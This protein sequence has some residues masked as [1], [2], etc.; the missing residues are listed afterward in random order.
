MSEKI[1]PKNTFLNLPVEKRQ[2]IVREA[3]RE[4][5][6]KG[7]RN[8][9]LNAIVSRLGI[10]KGSLYQ[11]FDN[12]EGLFLHVF[13]QFTGLV[14]STLADVAAAASRQGF[15]EQVRS[16]LLAGIRLIDNYPEYYEIYL[17]LLFE[18][19]VPQREELI[20]KVRLF[21]RDYFSPLCE[22]GRRQGTIRRDLS[23]EVVVFILDAALDRFLQGYARS[24]L[25]GGLN[26]AGKN[27][28][29]LDET[30]SMVVAVLRDGL[31]PGNENAT[32]RT[33][34]YRTAEPQ[35]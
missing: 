34:E 4:F 22:E 7:Y 3:V 32:R 19:A 11:Y 10:A 18:Q 20:A 2:R 14:K 24:Y 6:E 8:A 29:E 13:D 17:K 35:K 30:V 27:R 26:L 31:A 1:I 23:S 33:A 16:A 9:S 5:A 25:D 28:Q 21:S 12:K 15:F